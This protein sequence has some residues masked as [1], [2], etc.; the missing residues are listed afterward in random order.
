MNIVNIIE[1]EFLSNT[2][3]EKASTLQRFFKTGKGE[4]GENDIFCGIVV[5]DIR[6]CVK[7]FYNKMNFVDILHFI[8]SNYHEFRLFGLLVLIEKYENEKLFEK[9]QK[10]INIYI[11][12]IDYANNWDLVDLT[13]Y[14]LLGK[15]L[16]DFN[17][18]R[19]LLYDFAISNSI[20][21]RRIAMVS[22]MYFVK[23]NNFT[24]TL[25]IAKILIL[26]KYDLIQKS[27]G[28]LLR[29]VGKRDLDIL[30][31]FLFE[32]IKNIQSITFNYATEKFTKEEKD[33]FKKLRK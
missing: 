21:K 17:L 8:H 22:T 26:D 18:E 2:S 9:K 11:N 25:N 15:F 1:K 4:Y 13:C 30:K 16:Y 14:K 20:W 32:N 23:K 6:K 29:E 28:W 27:V 3:P 7:K 33:Y 31:N 5:P 24:D 12:N 10:I 19:Q